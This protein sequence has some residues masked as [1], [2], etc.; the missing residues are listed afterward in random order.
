[1]LIPSRNNILLNESESIINKYINIDIF[2]HFAIIYY[3]DTGL[4][5]NLFEIIHND[6]IRNFNLNKYIIRESYTNIDYDL[7]TN[8]CFNIL[9]KIFD[10]SI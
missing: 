4:M 9:D 6:N 10:S 2:N 5:Y 3:T 1:M 8:S 7:P